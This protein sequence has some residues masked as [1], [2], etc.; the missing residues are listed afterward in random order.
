MNL[1][2]YLDAA[3]QAEARVSDL[4]AQIDEH[5]EAGETDKALSL[6]A[7]LDAAKEKALSAHNLYLSML[8]AT[9]GGEDPG[10]RF[11]PVGGRVDVIED[12]ADKEFANDGEFFMAVKTAALYPAR[13]DA[14]LRS[15]KVVDATGMSEG[16]PAD[17]GYLLQPQTSARILENMYQTGE[18]LSRVARDPIGAGS[19]SITYNG[20]D[21]ISRK[22][23]SRKGGITAG[24][25]GEGGTLSAS[26]PKF[27]Q[28]EIKLR[29]L[30]ALCYATDEQLE[31]LP[32]LE[33]WLSRSVPEE[34]RFMAEDAII[35]GT[36]GGMPLGILNAPALLSLP[37]AETSKVL[38]ADI[39]N[40]WSRRY[41][42]VNDYVWLI[43]QDV[44]PQLDQ[45][46]IGTEAPPRFVDYGVDGVM[47]MKGR[48]VIEVEYA[49]TLGTAGD[50]LLASLSQY[51]VIDKG[52]VLQASSI[53]VQF[54]TDET[55]FRF[56]YRINGAPLWHSPVE[57]KNGS[58]TI[59]PFVSLSA[60]TA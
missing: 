57:P 27:R 38:F 56:I 23:G 28:V 15:R 48:P 36:G 50:I 51:Q 46:V 30:G 35:E 49:Q 26:K 4:A 21:E 12:E 31:D 2:K 16:V 8:N 13:A 37:R 40:M 6:K 34:L 43:H 42:G 33:S 55:A 11:A 14:R 59:S 41:A 1:K 10:Q 25:L 29:K 39:V 47:R 44:T 52:D 9:S 7:D 60:A 19:N 24:W 53:H 45:M 18:I 58:K 22:N 54:L 5:F 20:I 3:N 32:N 17:G